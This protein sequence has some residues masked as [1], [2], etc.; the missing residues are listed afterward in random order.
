MAVSAA[1]TDTTSA[2]LYAAL[3]GTK[4]SETKSATES[5]RRAGSPPPCRT[6][7]ITIK[8]RVA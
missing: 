2:A 4:A 8:R 7:M 5:T 1:A 6:W 3:N